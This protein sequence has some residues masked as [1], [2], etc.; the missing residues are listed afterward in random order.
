MTLRSAARA[1]KGLFVQLLA[2]ADKTFV[3]RLS[4]RKMLATQGFVFLEL[5]VERLYMLGGLGV[6]FFRVNEYVV[7]SQ[8]L[9]V[10]C[11]P[12]HRLCPLK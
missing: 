8:G 2:K 11:I 4:A 1:S 12:F 5:L 6:D 10:L 3:V 9:H 7:A